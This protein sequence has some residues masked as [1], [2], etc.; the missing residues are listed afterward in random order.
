MFLLF[1]FFFSSSSLLTSHVCQSLSLTDKV[2]P[3][4]SHHF[5]FLLQYPSPTVHVDEII[6][7]LRDLISCGILFFSPSK[8]HS[9]FR[10]TSFYYFSTSFNPFQ[11][12]A[13]DLDFTLFVFFL[14]CFIFLSSVLDSENRVLNVR[15]TKDLTTRDWMQNSSRIR[16]EFQLTYIR[17][18]P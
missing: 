15:L 17:I 11:V 18:I 9:F 10:C 7:F 16:R 2:F 8:L 5:L 12:T 3:W 13:C 6:V 1:F 4:K 14:S